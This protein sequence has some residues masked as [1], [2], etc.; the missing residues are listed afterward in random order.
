MKKKS[1]I[2]ILLTA[3]LLTVGMTAAPV[4]AE[5]SSYNEEFFFDGSKIQSTMDPGDLAAAV[6]EMEPGD[7]VSYSVKNTNQSDD[8][9]DWHLS[10]E[11]LQTLEKTSQ[12]KKVPEGTGTPENGGYTYSLIHTDKNGKK[13]TIFSSGKVGGEAKPGGMQGLEQATNATEAWFFIQR[14]EKKG[15]YGKL[16]LKVA[17]EG[18][19]EVNDYMDTEG[20][21]ALRLAVEKVKKGSKKPSESPSDDAAVNIPQTGDDSNMFIPFLIMLIAGTAL[22]ILVF[23][24]L[25]RRDEETGG[26]A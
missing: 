14:L 17:F 25:R 20:S 9:T 3:I 6:T 4:M 16:D 22:L 26:N 10:N 11:V 2:M 24:K 19:T 18:E 13:T 5:S 12:A 15:D 7:S 1:K 23:A 8:A 21:L